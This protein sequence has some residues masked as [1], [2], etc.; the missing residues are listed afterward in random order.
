MEINIYAGCSFLAGC[1]ENFGIYYEDF[2]WMCR[3]T[4]K[5]C[6]R[7]RKPFFRGRIA[8][9]FFLLCAQLLPTQSQVNIE[10]YFDDAFLWTKHEIFETIRNITGNT[11]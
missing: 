6:Y 11:A 8:F 4:W 10:R 7:N 9:I 5:I 1:Y 3:S 2:L